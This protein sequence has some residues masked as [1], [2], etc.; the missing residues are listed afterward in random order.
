MIGDREETVVSETTPDGTTVIRLRGDLDDD[1]APSLTRALAAAA[2]G[3]S[4]R[5]V[6]DLSG[7]RFAD[8]SALHA[9][10]EAQQAHAATGTALVLAGP[11]QTGVR[12]LF[13]VTD[14]G[15]AFRWADSVRD[16]MT[17]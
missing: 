6:A 5:T 2:A 11:L 12:R 1:S 4:S 8:S 17:P 14:T 13:E 16:G 9:L 10:L 3:T 15:S 7:V